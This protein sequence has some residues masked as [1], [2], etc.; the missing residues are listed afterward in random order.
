[1]MYYLVALDACWFSLVL[2][3]ALHQGSLRDNRELSLTTGAYVPILFC[4]SIS[5]GYPASSFI[6]RLRLRAAVLF[7]HMC[8]VTAQAY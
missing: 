6:F 4:C 7:E 8:L 5:R 2:F 1:M 3:Y